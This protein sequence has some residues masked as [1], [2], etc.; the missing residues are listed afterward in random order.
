MAIEFPNQGMRDI[1]LEQLEINSSQDQEIGSIIIDKNTVFLPA[2]LSES[3]LL[4]V[5]FPTV[6][7][8]DNFIHLLNLDNAKL[9]V[10]KSDDCDLYIN[11][12]RIHDTASRFHI[13]VICPYFT[14]YYKIQYDS[15]MLAQ[16]YRD[17]N[18]FFRK[19]KFPVELAVKIASDI[20]SSD[21]ISTND[22]MQIAICNFRRP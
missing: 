1:F 18:S 17:C 20:S 8:K 22:K 16:A 13:A 5:T 9:I 19:K 14:E 4:G 2:L 15:H 7:S 6:K 10:S 11:D 21:A 12:R 3:Q